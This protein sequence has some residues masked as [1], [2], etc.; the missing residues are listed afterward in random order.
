MLIYYQCILIVD[1]LALWTTLSYIAGTI[2]WKQD[3]KLVALHS[4]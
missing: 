1:L 2:A 4:E 3:Q